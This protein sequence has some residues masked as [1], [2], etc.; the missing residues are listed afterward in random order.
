MAYLDLEK[1]WRVLSRYPNV[2]GLSNKL[3]PRI[4]EGKE[5]PEELCLRVYVTKKVPL[6]VLKPNEVIPREV[7][8]IPV[9][10]VEIGELKALTDK[11]SK[12][13]PLM[14]GISIG[15]VEVTAGT[16]GWF[17]RKGDKTLLGSN[18]HVFVGDP[19]LDPEKVEIKDIIQPGRADGGT[20]EDRVAIYLWHEPIVEWHKESECPIAKLIVEAYNFAAKLLEAR[21]RLRAVVE[22]VN[23]VDFAVA[24]PLVDLDIKA[25]DLEVT[26]KLVGLGFA[27]SDKA[28]LVCKASRIAQLGFEPE[29][30]VPVEIG[31]GDR[32][33]KTGRTSCTTRGT[34]LDSSATLLVSYGGWKALFADVVLTT[35]ILEPGDSGS[36][37]WLED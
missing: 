14:A 37:V 25:V 19:R 23:F 13:R 26:G 6:A 35:K 32:V 27:G 2:V 20:I 33:V 36:S 1:L 18:A 3:M 22:A 29:N 24:E 12:F 21:T 30:A 16:L 8:G 31:E 28:S 11:R 15:S 10:V 34:V 5:I 9:D 7:E 4:R 17:F